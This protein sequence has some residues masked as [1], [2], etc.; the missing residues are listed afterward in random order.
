MA[1]ILIIGV[2]AGLVSALLFGVV[3]TGSPLAMLL[4]VVAPLPIFIAALGWSHFS[5]LVASISGGLA[6]TAALNLTAGLAFTLGWALPAWWLAYLALL[7]RPAADGSTEWYPLGRLLAWIALTAALITFVGVLAIGGF[8]YAAFSETLRRVFDGL[9]QGQGGTPAPEA[10]PTLRILIELLPLFFALNFV[11][12]L[13]L[14][15]WLAG[16]AVR[17]SDRLPRPWPDIPATAMS[18]PALVA[19]AVS[20]ALSFAPGL[21]GAAGMV[22]AGAFF[23][24]FVLQGL[25]FVHDTTRQRPG[26]GFLLGGLYVLT[27]FLSQIAMP[28]LAVL[29]C[30]DAAFALR[31]RFKP[32][33]AGPPP[34]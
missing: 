33:A 2:G 24:A 20:V 31:A 3:I 26:R 15:L 34:R 1:N 21:I 13:T 17:L 16:K 11:L 23:A 7:G 27:L 18:S 12:I 6:M 29:G 8:S 32:G 9:L 14:N 22:L 19:L 28:L 10:S 25:A 4:S 30:A 5:G